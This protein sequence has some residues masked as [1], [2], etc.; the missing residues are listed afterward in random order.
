MHYLRK[1]H[2]ILLTAENLMLVLLLL[3]MIAIAV[4]QILLRNFFG[5]GLLWADGFTRTCVLW[6]ALLG[7]MT[8]SRHQRHIAIDVLVQRLPKRLKGLA[9]RLSHFLTGL[10]CLFASWVSVG[11]VMQEYQFGG[12]AFANMPNWLCQA[13][14]PLGLAIIALRYG[15]AAF[16]PNPSG[17]RQ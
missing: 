8:A 16:L 5:G 11:F 13:I 14:I 1:L 6:L 7:A 17:H 15:I 9:I 12:S 4:V 2:Q 10:V 3:S